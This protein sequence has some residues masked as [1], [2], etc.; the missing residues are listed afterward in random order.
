MPRVAIVWNVVALALLW[1]RAA[2]LAADAPPS[3]PVHFDLGGTPDRWGAPE[4]YYWMPGVATGMT[5]LLVTIGLALPSM[6]RS[7]G[8][9]INL[10]RK[11]KF[12]RLSPEAR[13]RAV[14]PLGSMLGWLPL[15][16]DF[17]CVWLLEES[18]RIA[19][20]G[21]HAGET[22]PLIPLV[23]PMIGILGVVLG[24]SARAARAIDAEHAAENAALS[25]EPMA[26]APPPR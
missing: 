9:W 3:V 18:A 22:L 23:L 13:V 5:A 6:A 26:D 25:P 1:W 15:G 4:S 21:P 19:L 20:R 17:L 16:V 8:T 2:S 7:G 24:F 11:E 10:P 14:A 12:L